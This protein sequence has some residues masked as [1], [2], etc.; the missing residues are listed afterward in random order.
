MRRTAFGSLR[1]WDSL[2]DLL[3]T[4]PEWRFAAPML[5]VAALVVALVAATVGFQA[6]YADRIAA[7]VTVMGVELGGRTKAEARALLAAEVAEM[8]RQP[9]TLRLDGQ[10]A[11]RS[12]SKRSTPRPRRPRC[13][14]SNRSRRCC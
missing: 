9:V 10:R 6:A 11:P 12:A 2:L 7:G 8:G 4:P 3:A 1:H 14:A 5:G 13:S